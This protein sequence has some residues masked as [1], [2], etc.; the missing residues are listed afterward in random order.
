MVDKGAEGTWGQRWRDREVEEEE[1]EEESKRGI[2]L[3]GV[4][5]H[6]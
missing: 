5:G 3:K 4:G 1:E 6:R 2:V